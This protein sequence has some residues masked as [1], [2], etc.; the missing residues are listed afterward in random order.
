[1]TLVNMLSQHD[2]ACVAVTRLYKL[3]RRSPATRSGAARW[4]PGWQD[5]GP[6]ASA[7]L[8]LLAE[9]GYLQVVADDIDN[10]VLYSLTTRTRK[11]RPRIAIGAAPGNTPLFPVRLGQTLFGQIPPPDRVYRGPAG[12][13]APYEYRQ[14]YHGARPGGY[15]DWTCTYNAA[16]AGQPAILPA[17][18]PVPPWKDALAG[19]QWLAEL[20]D[21]QR[22]H[23]DRSRAGTVINTVT[24]EHFLSDRSERTRYGPDQELVRLLS[25][26]TSG[27]R[28]RVP[29]IGQIITR[30]RNRRNHIPADPS[31]ADRSPSL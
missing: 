13:T 4:Q 26:Q 28:K 20:T 22:A 2:W 10:V 11:F 23:L 19:R 30:I 14:S 3:L 1:M 7:M 18:V 8:W 31:E 9:D 12:A 27:W 25:P 5:P 16:G 6:A 29:S 15:A 17:D 21:D 24:I